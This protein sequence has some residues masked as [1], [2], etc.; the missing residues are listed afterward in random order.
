MSVA[1]IYHSSYGHTRVIADSIARGLDYSN[2]EVRLI[3][4]DEIQ[5][6]EAFNAC[7]VDLNSFDG[8][9]FGCPTY[10]GGPSAQFKAF[11]DRTSSVWF[12]QGW[13]NK[14]AGGFTCSGNPS[15]DKL[16]TLQALAIFAAQHSMLWV[17]QGHIAA[18]EGN[19][20]NPE[21]NRLGSFLGCMAQAG[22]VPA[23]QEPG[24]ADQLTAELYGRRIGE[25][26]RTWRRG[27]IQH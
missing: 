24:P 20:S 23:D 19:N 18:N 26:V 11:M 4:V 12:R 9:V 3:N 2:L 7:M 16:A 15:G 13:K 21:V 25:V 1:V 14:I 5:S 17:N 6:Q 22:Q 8:I 27:L 10:M